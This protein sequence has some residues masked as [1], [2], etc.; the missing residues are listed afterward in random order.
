[1][2]TEISSETHHSANTDDNH[3]TCDTTDEDPRPAKRRKPRS[4][5]ALTVPLHLRQSRPR[6]SHSTTS[7][8]IDDA[9]PQ[10][11]CGYRSTLV[12]DEPVA[13]Y[14][15]WPFQGFLKRTKIGNE[16]TYNLEF[17]LP[18]IPEHLYLPIPFDAL[19]IG[20]N[21]GTSAEVETPH[22]AVAHSEV[23]PTTF[24]ISKTGFKRAGNFWWCRSSWHLQWLPNRPNR[25]AGS[26]RII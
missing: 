26:G 23:W 13:E 11:N 2:H 6:V 21:T 17:Q 7:L 9:Q 25:V 8:E 1:M 14:Q 24:V 12:D 22:S 3:N 20:S 16:S 15:E 5:P 19:S 10:A 18:R 4:A